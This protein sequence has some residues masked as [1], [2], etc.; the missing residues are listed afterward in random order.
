MEHYV[1]K[2]NET[3]LFRGTACLLPDG[4][5]ARGSDK[6]FDVLLTNLSIVLTRTAK[7]LFQSIEE[8][9]VHRVADV[10]TY[11]ETVQ[12]L[13]R[14]ST[15]D[16]YLTTGELFLSF[17]KEREAK[18]FCAKAQRLIS[19]E[20]KLVRSVKKAKRAVNETGE[21]L[22]IDFV[23]V[24]KSALA[25]AGSVAIGI[26]SMPDAG[27]KSRAVATVVKQL[28]PSHKKKEAA[29]LAKPTAQGSTE[30]TTAAEDEATT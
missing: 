29:A 27:K 30:K 9:Y 8:T 7:R 20:S 13:R 24:G 22:D 21:A 11:D 5:Q 26:G 18:E 3:I 28:L 25:V 14:R 10:K 17:E 23:E 15:V 2:E 19:G 16:V 12:V 6:P 4:K 1:L